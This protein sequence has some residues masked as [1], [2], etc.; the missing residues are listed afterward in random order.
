[1]FESPPLFQEIQKVSG[2]SDQEMHQVYN[3]GHRFEAYC[4][5]EAVDA[6]I[7]IGSSFGIEA[8]RVGYT[9]ESRERGSLQPS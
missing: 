5:P 2:T 3:M 4:E 1:M 8:K 6:L 9:E 7:S